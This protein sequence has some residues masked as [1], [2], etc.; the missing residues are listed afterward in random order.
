MTDPIAPTTSNSVDPRLNCAA[1]ICCG[2]GGSLAAATSILVDAGCPNEYA[3][4]CA[5]N[6]RERGITFTSVA[7][8]EAMADIADHPGR[9]TA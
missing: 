9:K 2:P 1:G 4:S 8:A 3:A 7:L 6:L 5:R